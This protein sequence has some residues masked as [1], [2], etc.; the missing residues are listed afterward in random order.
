[1]VPTPS[2][3]EITRRLFLSR[4]LKWLLALTSTTLVLPLLRFT[5]YTVKSPPE[6]VIV[7]KPLIP[8]R[9]V[10][11]DKF[12]L[13]LLKGKP[14]AVSRRCTHLG[15]KVNYRQDLDLIECPCH[16][17]RFTTRGKRVAGPAEKD[18]PLFPV[19]IL[20]DE[21]GAPAGYEVRI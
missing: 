18:L 12:I 1:M 15:C 9:A 20:E 3:S 19:R 14:V 17:S 4:Q 11:G 13:F 6:I 8:G 5:G 21:T 10:T 2:R 16:Q 7:D